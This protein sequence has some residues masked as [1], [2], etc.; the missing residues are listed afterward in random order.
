MFRDWAVLFQFN[1]N[2]ATCS[3]LPQAGEGLGMRDFARNET[4]FCS[5]SLTLTLSRLRDNQR[6]SGYAA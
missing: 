1:F 5:T 6:L 4:R 2:V 3:L